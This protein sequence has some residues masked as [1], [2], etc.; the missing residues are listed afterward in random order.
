MKALILR[1]VICIFFFSFSLYSYIDKQNELTKLKLSLP[2]ITKEIKV[3]H[4]E[5]T[6]LAFE[7]E[8][9]ESPQHLLALSKEYGHLKY[10]CFNDI[11]TVKEGIALQ[12]EPVSELEVSDAKPK[13]S[14]AFGTNP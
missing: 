4:E 7:I 8:S 1:V 3:I 6:R 2:R 12:S 9:F 11:L 10:P 14:F 5:N 13:V